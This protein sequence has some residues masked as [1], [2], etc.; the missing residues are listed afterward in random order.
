MKNFSYSQR[1]ILT[2]SMYASGEFCRELIR[3]ITGNE[4]EAT[5]NYRDVVVTK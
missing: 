3:R 2:T 5:K 1:L 4:S